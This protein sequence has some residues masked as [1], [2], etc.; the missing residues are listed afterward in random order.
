MSTLLL[1]TR[2]FTQ[3]LVSTQGFEGLGMGAMRNI[4]VKH[5]L[6]C[7]LR[8]RDQCLGPSGHECWYVGPSGHEWQESL[9]ML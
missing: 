3:F 7:I 8:Q 9:I 1:T 2:S 5:I 6:G 4:M